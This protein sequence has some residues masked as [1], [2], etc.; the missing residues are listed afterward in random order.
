M[1]NQKHSPAPAYRLRCVDVKIGQY[2]PVNP[3]NYQSIAFDIQRPSIL[4]SVLML[5]PM[6]AGGVIYPN[7]PAMSLSTNILIGI[8]DEGGRRLHHRHTLLCAIDSTGYS[9]NVFQDFFRADMSEIEIPAGRYY[10]LTSYAT[11]ENFTIQLL[12][13][14]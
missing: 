1:V 8:Y 11:N 13:R 3:G 10:L 14:I 5:G 2:D 7:G 9:S 6:A 12:E 4:A